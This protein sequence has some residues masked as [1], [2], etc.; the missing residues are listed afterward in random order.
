MSGRLFA[1]LL[2]LWIVVVLAP[3]IMLAA[4]PSFTGNL[5]LVSSRFISLRLADGRVVHVRLPKS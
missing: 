2:L 5:V 3:C 1:V 4:D